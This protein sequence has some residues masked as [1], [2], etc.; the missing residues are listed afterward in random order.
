MKFRYLLWVAAA[1][2]ACTK[3]APEPVG[4]FDST[5]VQFRALSGQTRVSFETDA[6]NALNITWDLTDK[7]GISACQGED[8]VGV[9]YPYIIKDEN[10]ILEPSSSHYAYKK[11]SQEMTYYAYYPYAGEPGDGAHYIAP[12]TLPSEQNFNAQKPLMYLHDYWVMRAAPCTVASAAQ[13]VDFTFSGVF[14]I[15]ELKLVYSK[16][17][18]KNYPL[19]KISLKSAGAP[20]AIAQGNLNLTATDKAQQLIVNS[21]VDSVALIMDAAVNL[22]E[23]EAKAFYL[24]VAPGQHQSVS[25]DLISNNS[26]KAEVQIDGAV[27][28]APNTV[29]HKTVTVDPDTFKWFAQNEGDVQPMKTVYAPVAT[30]EEIVDG[31][32]IIGFLHNDGDYYVLP[33]APIDRNPAMVSFEAASV[34]SD[35]QSNIL[36]VADGYEWIVDNTG[37]EWTFRT[38]DGNFLVGGNKAQG[39]AISN[40]NTGYYTKQGIT[41]YEKWILTTL[42]NGNITM[43][44]VSVSRYF[45]LI[46]ASSW[47]QFGTEAEVTGTLVFYKK[48]EIAE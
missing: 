48:T 26:Y 3:N 33:T 38:A 20:L 30:V 24:V 42:D 37:S 15:I 8:V 13:T 39:I 21:P 22:S 36:S 43:C 14:S 18:A 25:L 27:T 16:A 29:Y 47:Y 31:E 12:M 23:S 4:S 5:N 45:T 2:A 32:Y 7:I 41:Y 10:N 19:E 9:N 40:N 44:P 35:A 6:E 1:L 11:S 34:E 17:A 46:E 28:F